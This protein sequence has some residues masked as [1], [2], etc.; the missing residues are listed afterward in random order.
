MCDSEAHSDEYDM[1]LRGLH[2]H[3]ESMELRE[4]AEQRHAN[5]EPWRGR[6]N[7]EPLHGRAN[8]AP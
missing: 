5:V 4:N 8:G 3:V 1:S 6:A 2:G 7:V